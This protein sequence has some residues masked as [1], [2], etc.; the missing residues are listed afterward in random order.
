MRPLFS[1]HHGREVK[2]LGDGFLVEFA[3]ATDAINCAHEIQTRIHDHNQEQPEARKLHLRVGVHLGDVTSSEGDISGDAV[4]VASRIEALAPEGGVCLTRQVYDQVW[5]KMDF[6]FETLGTKALKNIIKPVEVYRIVMPWEEDKPQRPHKN[7]FDRT[8]IAVMPF[9]NMSPDPN[10][11]YFADGITEEIISTLSSISSLGVI[12]RTSVMSDKGTTKN[13]K[14]VGEELQVGSVLEGSFR[15]AGNR[16]RISTQ[17]IDANNDRHVWSQSYDIELNDVFTI[18]SEIAEKVADA[19]KTRLVLPSERKAPQ[20]IPPINLEAYN[21][22]LKARYLMTEGS[23]ASIRQSLE[24]FH[25]VT[26]LDPQLVRAFV[27]I[28]ESYSQLAYRSLLS[29]E[30]AVAGIKSSAQDVGT[31][32]YVVCSGAG[33]TVDYSLS[34]SVSANFV[35]VGFPVYPGDVIKTTAY[36]NPLTGATYLTVEDATSGHSFFL[37][38]AGSVPLNTGYGGSFSWVIYS[39]PSTSLPVPAF[40]PI[41]FSGI[42]ATIDDHTGNLGLFTSIKGISVDQI[43]MFNPADKHVL[44]KASSIGSASKSFNLKWVTGI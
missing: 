6:R 11:S 7:D 12:S 15:K 37:G 18:Q 22:Y 19:L 41:K 28:G 44:V 31:Q 40:T 8:R 23:D 9:A 5:N 17:L 36:E 34:Y 14:Q 35:G 25:Q 29:F 2:T 32:L 27:G 24:M 20:V 21:F 10:D 16:I 26:K 38:Q 42:K 3:S 13:L 1:K 43:N 4:N 33:A 30:E 39:T